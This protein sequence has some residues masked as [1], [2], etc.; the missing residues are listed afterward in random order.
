[1]TSVLGL[2]LLGLGSQVRVNITVT[3]IIINFTMTKI[4]LAIV[5]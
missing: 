5:S 4:I 3:K 2:G 1:M